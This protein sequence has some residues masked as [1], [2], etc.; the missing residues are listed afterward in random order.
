MENWPDIRWYEE[1]DS[2]NSELR[3]HIKE[4]DNLSVIAAYCQS[5][6]RGQGDHKWS[7]RRGENLTFTILLRFR[8]LD[9][10]D[11]LLITCIITLA[12]RDFLLEEGVE[13]RIKW[14]NDIWVGDRKICGILIENILDHDKVAESIVGI[15]LNLNQ[16]SWP[17]DIPNPTSLKLLTG[18]DYSL[19]DTLVRLHENIR[20]RYA[21]LDADG[22]R[23]ALKE[24]FERYMFT[25]PA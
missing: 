10:S 2:T 24:E 20:L 5:A 19:E 7:S 3:R 9:V 21:M 22:G 13:A 1:L 12:L 23:N 16:D 14:P 4:L 11:A 18:R 17:E 6:G 25:L 8:D 15:G